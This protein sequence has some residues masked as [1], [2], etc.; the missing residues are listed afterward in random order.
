MLGILALFLTS[1]YLV[2][3]SV[4][5]YR[6]YNSDIYQ[7]LAVLKE[8]DA[9]KLGDAFFVSGPVDLHAGPYFYAVHLVSEV[10]GSSDYQT[11]MVVTAINVMFVL[12]SLY[13]FAKSFHFTRTQT[14]LFVVVSLVGWGGFTFFFAGIY[15][16]TNL[17]VSGAF[18]ATIGF[19]LI[20]L[21]LGIAKRYLEKP[22]LMLLLFYGLSLVTLLLSHLLSGVVFLSFLALLF[23]ER[24][25]IERRITRELV[26][27]GVATVCGAMAS[28]VIWP[29]F[30]LLDLFRNAKTVEVGTSSKVT[31]NYFSFDAWP[32]LLGVTI[33]GFVFLPKLWSKK[34]YFVFFLAIF[35]AAMTISYALPIRVSLYWR[36]FPFLFMGLSLALAIYAST[37]HPRLLIVLVVVMSLVGMLNI[38]NKLNILWL[39]APSPEQ[40]YS[41]VAKK[42]PAGSVVFSDPNTS[43]HLASLYPIRVVAVPY[44]HANPAFIAQ[45]K[46]RYDETIRLLK[47]S[48]SAGQQEA[49]MKRYGVQYVLLNENYYPDN[50]KVTDDAELN[51]F[52][53][54]APAHLLANQGGL[55]LYRLAQ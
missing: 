37:L 36:Y 42:I 8:F 44:G 6:L 11:L 48:E 43:Y 25:M 45:S 52:S 23:L 35:S 53:L 3:T 16:Y 39:R 7:E 40:Q 33:L 1:L 4:I 27:L 38:Y 20:L 49:F 29:P 18:P 9:G 46:R 19:G 32:S 55:R 17:L 13:F 41:E 22:S 2:W 51:K 10:T 30:G 28:V 15:E 14:L 54:E 47:G 26:L 34:Q 50:V 24:L 21:L 5:P 12:F 31:A